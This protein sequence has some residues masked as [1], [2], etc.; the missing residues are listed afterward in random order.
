[1]AEGGGGQSRVEE[2][3]QARM[4]AAS[5][6][7]VSPPMTPPPHTYMYTNTHTHIHLHIYVHYVPEAEI[8]K[9]SQSL[10]KGL[11]PGWVGSNFSAKSISKKLRARQ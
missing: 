4:A 11:S 5:G 1:M 6:F 3:L 10:F 2:E 9:Q 8:R 7:K